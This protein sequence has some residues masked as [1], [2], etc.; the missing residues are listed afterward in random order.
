[1]QLAIGVQGNA[2]LWHEIILAIEGIFVSQIAMKTYL[3]KGT[4]YFTFAFGG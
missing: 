4:A 3:Q 2:Q 1:M